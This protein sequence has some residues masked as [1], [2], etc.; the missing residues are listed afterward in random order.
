LGD[1]MRNKLCFALLFMCAGI[2]PAAAQ[3][4]LETQSSPIS[5]V[6]VEP[7]QQDIQLPDAPIPVLPG[8]QDGPMPCPLGI[9][10][11]CALLGGRLYFS[12]PSHMTRHDRKWGDALKNPVILAGMAVNTAALVWDYR[13]TRACLDKRTHTCK[14]AN[15][16]MGQSK[17]QEL[18]VG[19][20]VNALFYFVTVQ[21]KQRGKGNWALAALAAN[22]SLHFYFASRN[23]TISK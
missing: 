6:L 2:N 14:E 18:G 1:S 20:S 4:V 15:P 12:D 10:R 17:A 13:T 21:L 23:R 22:A 3:A 19:L 11:P 8:K 5:S 9:G 16:I 7:T